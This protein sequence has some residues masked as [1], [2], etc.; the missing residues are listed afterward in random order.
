MNIY[1][2]K[3]IHT[4]KLNNPLLNDDLVKE[5]IKREIKGFLELNENE[6]AKFQILGDTMK[7]VVK[8][9]LITL[10]AC[11][12]KLKRAYNS[13]LTPHLKALEQKKQLLPIF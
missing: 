5:E 3:H 6:D 2:G 11:K 4:W 9:K 12:M 7:A 1:N 10:S 13:C 8:G